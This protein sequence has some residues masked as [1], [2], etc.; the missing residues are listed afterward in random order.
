MTKTRRLNV[1]LTRDELVALEAR[2]ALCGQSPHSYL[3][4]LIDQDLSGG[5]TPLMDALLPEI[6]RT[7]VATN[8][9]VTLTGGRND[10]ADLMAETKRTSRA[11]GVDHV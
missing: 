7:A 3:R 5:A 6:T 9:L 4:I 8:H 10:L 11:L 2:A 1:R